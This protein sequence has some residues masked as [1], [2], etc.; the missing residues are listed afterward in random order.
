M[1]SNLVNEII[2]IDE[3]VA[4][5]TACRLTNEAGANVASVRQ[6]E[7]RKENQCKKIVA[8]IC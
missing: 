3:A 8:D 1:N 4:V 6:F 2:R 7:S 5:E